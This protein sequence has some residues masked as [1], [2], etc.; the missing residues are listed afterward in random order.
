MTRRDIRSDERNRP[1]FVEVN[2]LAGLNPERS[3]LVFITRFKGIAYSDLIG[4]IMDS[5]AKR[6]PGLAVAPAA[7]STTAR[8]KRSRR[9]SVVG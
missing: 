4:R 6:Y 3:D 9:L 1:N 2:P 5:F 8:P 7:R